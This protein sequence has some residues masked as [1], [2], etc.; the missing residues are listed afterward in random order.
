M[1]ADASWANI[2]V[3]RNPDGSLDTFRPE[4]TV[5]LLADEQIDAIRPFAEELEIP[6]DQ[7]VFREGQTELDFLVVLRGGIEFS[8]SDSFGKKTGHVPLHALMNPLAVTAR[9]S[10]ARANPHATNKAISRTRTANAASNASRVRKLIVLL[11][12]SI[13]AS[14]SDRLV[15]HRNW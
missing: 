7:L 12:F 11:V 3:M 14:Q 13:S 6:A 4:E 15:T 1:A 5:A 10:V 9:V 8:A 2:L